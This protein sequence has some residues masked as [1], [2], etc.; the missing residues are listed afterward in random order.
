MRG[1]NAGAR[2]ALSSPALALV[3]LH[4]IDQLRSALGTAPAGGPEFLA[5]EPVVVLEEALD[6]VH[7]LRAQVL[8]VLDGSELPDLQAAREEAVALAGALLKEASEKF[9]SGEQ[10]HMDVTDGNGLVL[11]RLDFSATQHPERRVS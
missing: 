5:A 1:R 11:F 6:L 2:R 3:C 7:D 4:A 10:W 9:W 8:Q